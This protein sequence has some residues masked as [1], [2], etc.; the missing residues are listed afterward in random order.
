MSEIN[1]WFKTCD[2][3][4]CKE[5]PIQELCQAFIDINHEYT[6]FNSDTKSSVRETYSQLE[7]FT[8]KLV[9]AY[10]EVKERKGRS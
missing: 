4:N 9:S 7:Q 10:K 5:C 6:D 2:T 3:L 1:K 8:I